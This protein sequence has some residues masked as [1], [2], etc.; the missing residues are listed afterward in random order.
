MKKTI[1]FSIF[2]L[3]ALSCEEQ[4]VV[5]PDFVAPE[6][7]RVLLIEETSGVACPNCPSGSEQVE[8]IKQQF[9]G[10]V[11]SVV[12]YTDFLGAPLSEST[13]DL[14]TDEARAIETYLGSFIGKPSISVSRLFFEDEGFTWLWNDNLWADQ[15]NEVLSSSPT[16]AASVTIENSYNSTSRTL[17]AKVI[18]AS[19]SDITGDFRLGVMLTESGIIN[20][21]EDNRESDGL[22]EDYEHNHV[23]RTMLTAIEGDQIGSNLTVGNFV[24]RTYTFQIPDET[25]WWVPEN[26][27]VIAFLSLIDGDS[28]EV[29]QAAEAHVVE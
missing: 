17:T 5:I 7:S 15:V 21:Q 28:K 16:A 25:E 20:A 18:V 23:L 1:F 11:I 24:E 29:L 4:M 6:S 19:A 22:V 8:S 9:P 13:L 10:N 12:L 27:D 14:R 2:L 26:M 3:I